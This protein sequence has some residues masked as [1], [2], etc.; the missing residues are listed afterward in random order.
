MLQETSLVLGLLLCGGV[1]ALVVGFLPWVRPSSI[2]WGCMCT[3]AV[4]PVG[5]M[6]ALMSRN[7]VSDLSRVGAL[8][9][10]WQQSVLLACVVP[11]LCFGAL[12]LSRPTH[13]AISSLLGLG[14]LT[15][16]G[17]FFVTATSVLLWLLSFELLLLTSVYLLR[18]T[19]KSERIGEAVAEMFF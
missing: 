19:S 7:D 13:T 9:S 17:L 12:S 4:L 1:V 16:V 3:L 2:V 10:L 8:W 18:L 5:A 14:F 11:V 15:C 6:C